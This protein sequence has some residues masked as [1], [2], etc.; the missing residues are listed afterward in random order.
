MFKYNPALDA[1]IEIVEE[2]LKCLW[3][4]SK[5]VYGT[6]TW[7]SLTT[8]SVYYDRTIVS[9]HSDDTGFTS[10]KID[11]HQLMQVLREKGWVEKN[12]EL[13]LKDEFFRLTEP[14]RNL[15]LRD[16]YG[17][18]T[19]RRLREN[20]GPKAGAEITSRTQRAKLT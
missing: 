10:E 2:I 20:R 19:Y 3:E 8:L 12:E 18:E 5:R 11:F 1:H 6:W 16:K 14:T 13:F 9:V 4:K 7:V 15:L 17:R